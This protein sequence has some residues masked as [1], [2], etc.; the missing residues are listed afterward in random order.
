MMA[1]EKNRLDDSG[2]PE[3]TTISYILILLF[4]IFIVDLLQE[5]FFPLR[6]L[7]YKSTYKTLVH[8]ARLWI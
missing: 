5:D 3:H 7:Q 8:I 1:L 4:A 6:L 2:P